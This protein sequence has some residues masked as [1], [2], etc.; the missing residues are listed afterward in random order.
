MNIDDLLKELEIMQEQENNKKNKAKEAQE[1][2]DKIK[3]AAILE[4]REAIEAEKRIN[5][6]RVKVEEARSSMAAIDNKPV[7]T[8]KE[9]TSSKKTKQTGNRFVSGLV[10][11]ALLVS[12]VGGGITLVKQSKTGSVKFGNTMANLF[13]NKK[14]DET[15]E[16]N[17]GKN[18]VTVKNQDTKYVPLTTE[19]FEELCTKAIKIF[20][21]NGLVANEEDIIKFV[22]VFNID[23]L[24][25]D[26][27]ELLRNLMGTQTVEEFFADA[28][29]VSDTILNYESDTMFSVKDGEFVN[30][31]WRQYYYDLSNNNNLKR[32]FCPNTDLIMSVADFA[33]DSEQ[34]KL[35][36]DFEA[37]RNE[38]LKVDNIETR[39]K[40][41]QTLFED[42]VRSD[43]EFRLF[44]ESSKYFVLRHCFI[45][46]VEFYCRDY[47]ANKTNIDGIAYESLVRWIAPY[48]S[49]QYEYDNS[50]LAVTK[51]SMMESLKKC[52]LS[53]QSKTLTR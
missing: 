28:V 15:Y 39:N 34:Q 44:E 1:K 6:A 14:D 48:G 42:L 7:E 19:A 23:K 52:Q 8:V 43:S 29:R 25:Q 18:V 33:F 49:T 4:E 24:K 27:Q 40:M 10:T 46:L 3:E 36:S 38:I 17:Y 50:V 11:G 13:G 51:R 37:R 35:I 41:I 22:A 47:I 31:E 20:K 32:Q 45:D 12:L 2:A 5:A 16:Y 21:D 26:N 30:P 9:N 53:E